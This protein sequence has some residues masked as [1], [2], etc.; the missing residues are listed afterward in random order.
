MHSPLSSRTTESTHAAMFC[1]LKPHYN[2]P[3][4]SYFQQLEKGA[5]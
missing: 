4:K 3:N 5:L 2:N 1:Y